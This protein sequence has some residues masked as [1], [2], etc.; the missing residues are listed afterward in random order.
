MLNEK[1]YRRKN[2]YN[3]ASLHF[4]K[5]L[6]AGSQLP[7]LYVGLAFSQQ[8]AGNIDEAMQTCQQGITANPDNAE[9]HLRL[10]NLYHAR[11]LNEKAE[12]EYLLY[13]Q[14]STDL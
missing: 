10:G 1:Y 12:G 11:D 8:Q 13:R 3:K 6:A 4:N 5:A 7:A 14:L 9:L 2:N